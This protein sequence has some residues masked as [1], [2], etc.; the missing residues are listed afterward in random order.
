MFTSIAGTVRVSVSCRLSANR[1]FCFAVFKVST[2]KKGEKI[3]NIL[4][5]LLSGRVC[6][7]KMASY[8]S[9]FT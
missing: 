9:N 2:V 3:G 1:Y 5:L 4:S 7:F 6:K 8:F